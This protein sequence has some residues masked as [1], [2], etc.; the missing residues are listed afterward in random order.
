MKYARTTSE[1]MKT[2][3]E[4]FIAE[5]QKSLKKYLRINNKIL[6]LP[7]VCISCHYT[8]TEY[9]LKESYLECKNGICYRKEIIKQAD[10]IE[11]LCDELV[12]IEEDYPI[13]IEELNFKEG[14]YLRNNEYE[15]LSK[16]P[17]NPI[18]Y[19]AIWTDKGLIY[20]AK[21]NEKGELELL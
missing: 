12:L 5:K 20:V 8:E 21:M 3:I 18:I 11:E 19:G 7:E 4:H 1:E 15:F 17:E 6:M 9:E 10:T 2:N 16:L 14:T 13:I